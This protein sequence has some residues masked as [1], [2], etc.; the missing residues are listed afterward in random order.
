MSQRRAGFVAFC[1]AACLAQATFV[2]A[3]PRTERRAPKGAAAVA[4]EIVG[5]VLS[6]GLHGDAARR[7]VLDEFARR[8]KRM[9]IRASIAVGRLESRSAHI[10]SM[11]GRDAF[12]PASNTKLAS[13]LWVLDV[14]G[15]NHRFRTRA[16]TDDAGN[17]YV[18][19]GFDPSLTSASLATIANGLRA[20][21]IEEIAGDVVLDGTQLVPGLPAGYSR[22]EHGQAPYAAIPT[23]LSVNKGTVVAPGRGRRLVR[24]PDPQAVFGVHMRAALEEAGIRVGGQ[25][26]AGVTPPDALTRFIH[27][28]APLRDLLAQ[29][30]ATSNNFDHELM[31]LA[32][33]SYERGDAP[34][35]HADAAASL[36]RYLRKTV[37]LRGF[38]LGNASGLGEVNRFTSEHFIT[39]LR[40][41]QR[42]ERTAEL[43]SL[44]TSPGRP[45]TLASRMVGTAAEGRL[46]AKTGTDGRA[47]GLSGYIQGR[48]GR[49]VFSVLTDGHEKRRGSVRRYIDAF[50]VA[51]S[52]L[53]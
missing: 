16:A 46:F 18:M 52:Q 15:G 5:K 29:S 35:S 31:A 13:A 3:R 20:Q 22:F 51:L 34:V 44:M 14:L 45:G 49:V 53:E 1:I 10:V 23:A 24:A 27:E 39:I 48:A 6:R 30:L 40:H 32:A 17:L 50:G 36:S 2:A 19:G 47:L 25:V 9:G 11:A 41:A 12:N 8:A 21:G 42:H 43:L 4:R 28:S 7:A 38:S 26:R 37:G 33:A